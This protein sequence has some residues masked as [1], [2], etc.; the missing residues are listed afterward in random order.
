MTLRSDV[1]L[2]H[3]KLVVFLKRYRN[4]VLVD[5]VVVRKVQLQVERFVRRRPSFHGIAQ[6]QP[7]ERHSTSRSF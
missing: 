1:A 5:V 2:Q 7:P 6:R 4:R 3:G